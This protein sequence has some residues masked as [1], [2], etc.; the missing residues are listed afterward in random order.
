MS[1]ENYKLS[2]VHFFLNVGLTYRATLLSFIFILFF[3]VLIL[4]S[5]VYIFFVNNTLTIGHLLILIFLLPLIS[6]DILLYRI[7]SDKELKQEF[8]QAEKNKNNEKNYEP[9]KPEK[10]RKFF[11][12]FFACWGTFIA[13]SII[14]VLL[15]ILLDNVKYLLKFAPIY[16]TVGWVPV[17][18][19][20]WTFYSKKIK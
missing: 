16:F 12:V 11:Y 8:L 6:I 3:I 5:S 1:H 17:F 18:L 10:V 15:I 4:G 20:F 19:I 2:L 13:I 9:S 7:I 14:I